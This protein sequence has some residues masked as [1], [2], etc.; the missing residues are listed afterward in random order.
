MEIP[1]SPCSKE[2][3]VIFYLIAKLWYSN[4]S[5]V[6]IFT[7][8]LSPKWSL[9]RQFE[10]FQLWTQGEIM[11]VFRTTNGFE[12]TPRENL[13]GV[14]IKKRRSAHYDGMLDIVS[15]PHLESLWLYFKNPEVAIDE[16]KVAHVEPSHLHDGSGLH[17]WTSFSGGVPQYESYEGGRPVPKYVSDEQLSAFRELYDFLDGEP[18]S[19]YTEYR[20]EIVALT[21]LAVG[22]TR[23]QVLAIW[24]DPDQ[25]ELWMKRAKAAMSILQV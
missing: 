8:C 20:P 6:E 9:T 22:N 7:L 21:M 14:E 11:A 4:K 18:A 2:Q 25:K 24:N 13:R 1:S 5:F 17:V 23:E 16:N 12:L 15:Y 19:S 10:R 3:G